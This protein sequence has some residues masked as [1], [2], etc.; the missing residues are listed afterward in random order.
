MTWR[1]HRHGRRRRHIH[2][3]ER[4]SETRDC[5]FGAHPVQRPPPT[6]KQFTTILLLLLFATYCHKPNHHE[7]TSCS[8]SLVIHPTTLSLSI[9][10]IHVPLA[11]AMCVINCELGRRGEIFGG[12][13]SCMDYHLIW[14]NLVAYRAYSY[15][16]KWMGSDVVGMNFQDFST[17]QVLIESRN[18]KESFWGDCICLTKNFTKDLIFRS[19]TWDVCLC[20]SL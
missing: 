4:G 2:H 9:F 17:S 12:P 1:S 18:Q 16:Y 19:K 7:C 13:L 15:G 20:V 10:W 6:K 14:L 5:D 3:I 11:H 8:L